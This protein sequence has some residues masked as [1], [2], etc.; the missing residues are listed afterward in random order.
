[1]L[2]CN[3]THLFPC[4]LLN[5]LTNCKAGF[6]VGRGFIIDTPGVPQCEIQEC[7]VTTILFLLMAEI[8]STESLTTVFRL[9]ENMS[10][11]AHKFTGEAITLYKVPLY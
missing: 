9:C 3:F 5:S 2:L 7:L 10:Q 1:M 4:Y 6:E 8:L 11:R